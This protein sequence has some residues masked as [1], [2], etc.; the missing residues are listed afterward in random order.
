MIPA[1]MRA[2][3]KPTASRRRAR[4]PWRRSPGAGS[5]RCDGRELGPATRA[6]WKFL[7]GHLQPVLG[8]H[9]PVSFLALSGA[10]LSL[11]KTIIGAGAELF[12]FRS[13]RGHVGVLFLSRP[14]K[15]KASRIPNVPPT[16]SQPAVL[17]LSLVV[18]TSAQTGRFKLLHDEVWQTKQ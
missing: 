5:G 17:L 15:C 16:K 2:A 3:I 13:R 8:E 1:S 11:L 6:N 18:L 4:P 10:V 14:F 9:E 7:V 12:G